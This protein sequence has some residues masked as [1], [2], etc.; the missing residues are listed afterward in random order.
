MPLYDKGTFDMLSNGNGWRFPTGSAACAMR[1]LKPDDLRCIAVVALYRPGP[2]EN[3]KDY[4][5]RKHDLRRFHTCT[6]FD[7][8]LQKPMEL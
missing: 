6:R 8:C 7:P 3:I 5:T 1:G 2:M 4:V